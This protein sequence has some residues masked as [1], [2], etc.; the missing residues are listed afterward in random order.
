M[1]LNELSQSFKQLSLPS[2]RAKQV[3]AWMCR[4]VDDFNLMTDISK[5][6][7]KKLDE[8]YEI[9]TCK[10]T[11]KLISSL[12]ETVKYLFMLND[13]EFVESVVMKYKHGYSI[14]ISTQ[15]GCKM[16]CSFCAS[17]LN[18]FVRN[19]AASEM[20]S[21]ITTAQ[22]DLD[23][24]ISNIVLMG[25]GEPLDNFD[26]VVRFLQ[27]VSNDDGLNI[28]LRHISLSTSGLVPKIYDLM[29]L[30]LPITLSVSLHAPNDKIRSSIM[31]VNDKYGVN[32]LIDACKKYFSVTGRRISFE[33]AIIR[34]INDTPECAKQLSALLNG[35]CAHVNLIP[36]NPVKEN[37]Y[38]APER[39]NVAAFQNMLIKSGVNATVRRTLGQDINASCGQLRNQN[40]R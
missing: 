6:T 29:E 15:I 19:L 37:Q 18:G 12:D 35:M 10:I 40:K 31:K 39:S 28:G 5:D 33:Y 23:I 17:G 24:R 21:Q 2:F 26:N 4:G 25:M 36:A 16:G 34:G 8:I 13:G 27:L 32:Q 7:A 3:F 11:K 22:K 9:K 30:N 14:C 38:S 20:L 1:Y